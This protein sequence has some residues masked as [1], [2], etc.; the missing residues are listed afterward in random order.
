MSTKV[1]GG[2]LAVLLLWIT[3]GCNRDAKN[4]SDDVKPGDQQSRGA[5]GEPKLFNADSLAAGSSNASTGQNTRIGSSTSASVSSTTRFSNIAAAAGFD[6]VYVTGARGQSLMVETMG[7][8]CGVLDFDCDGHWDL[9]LGQGGNPSA[10]ATDLTQPN[11][12]L[13]RGVKDKTFLNV[14]DAA[15]GKSGFAYGQGVAVGD[16]DDDGFDDV[17]LTNVGEN[18]LLRNMGDGTFLDVTAT[19]GVSDTRWSSSAA[20]ADVN[21]D[22]LL[23]LYVCNYVDYDPHNPLDCRNDAGK[24]R[25]CHPREIDAVPD[26]CFI[27]LGNGRFSDQA[28]EMGLTGAGG[29]G[30]G[31]AIADFTGD[32]LPDIY[33]ANDTT[34]NF[35]FVNQGEGRFVEQATWL[36]CAMDRT[37]AYQ[38]SMGLGIGDFNRDG[39]L[40]IYSSHFYDDSN[41]LYQNLGER[42]FQDV[43]AML[44]LHEPTLQSLGFG[45]VIEDFDQNGFAEIFVT[46]GHIEN[47]SDNALHRMQPQLFAFDGKRFAQTSAEAGSFFSEKYVGRGV[48]SLDFDGD[49]DLDLVVVH[50]DA[51]AALLE[52][53]SPGG[54]WLNLTFRGRTD[55]RRGIGCRAVVDVA[56]QRWEQQLV[57]GGSY[58]SSRQ[59]IMAFG[60]GEL[61]GPASIDVHWPS[62]VVQKLENVAL[63][64]TLNVIEQAGV[65][66]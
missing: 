36:G 20:F 22:Q 16:F 15:I 11:D 17:Y 44:G 40:D 37:G 1:L 35:L 52:N 14:A 48:S 7:G 30:L 50:Q 61:K 43:T 34:A 19:S 29:K 6:F 51:N 26:A 42:G 27:N 4:P 33:V 54:A 64:Q 47:Y 13:Y 58:A 28:I 12:A 56:G 24:H 63:N 39:K 38:A 3:I 66:E 31:V 46:N 49:G 55:N 10:A 32:G 45:T 62:G 18:K 2:S 5:T 21:G 8:G 59:P 53:Q 23:D 25:I 60:F 57:A 41:T 9:M 65:T